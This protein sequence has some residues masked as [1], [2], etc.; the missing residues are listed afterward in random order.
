MIVTEMPPG[1]TVRRLST[2]IRPVT[3]TV[4]VTLWPAARVPD[5]GDTVSVPIR[6]DGMAIDHGTGPPDAGSVR[7]PPFPVL[8]RIV[9]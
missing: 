9:R 6:L 5:D 8:S 2:A 3:L 4:T 7:V 1:F